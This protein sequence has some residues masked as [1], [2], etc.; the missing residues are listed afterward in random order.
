MGDLNG[1][2]MSEE[3]FPVIGRKRCHLGYDRSRY[4]RCIL[5]LDGLGYL[6]N[7]RRRRV[8]D[9]KQPCVSE[10]LKVRKGMRGLHGKIPAR[11][12]DNERTEDELN[13]APRCQDDRIARTPV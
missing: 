9:S 3:M 10:C 12:V 7:E 6:A 5:G 2:G 8:D 4:N 13:L 11:F 1:L